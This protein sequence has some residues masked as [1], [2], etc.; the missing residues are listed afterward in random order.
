MLHVDMDA[1]YVSVSLIDRPELR[2]LPV[3]V[4]GGE[5]GVVLSAS[6]EARAYGVSSA[7]PMSRARRLCPQATIVPPD[8]TAYSEASAGVM[9]IFRSVTP[10]VEP[11]SL[12][13]AFLD[14]S[15]A[16]RRLGPADHIAELI[17]A[18]VTDE[19]GIT[20]SV[21][22]AGTKFVAKLASTSCKPDGLLV[23]RDSDVVTFLHPLP[24]RALWGVGEKTGEILDRLGLRTVGDLAHTPAGTLRRALGHATGSHL[25]A[26]SWGRDERVVVPYEPDRSTGA[27]ET[28]ARDVDDP[29]VVHRE[30]LRLSERT[31]ARMRAA[32]HVGRTVTV[33]VRFA[34]FTTITR[35]RTLPEHTDTGREIYTTARELFDGLGLQRA[36]LRLVGVRV[37]ALGPSGRPRQM[38]L[39]E[40]PAGWREADRAVDRA[41]SRFGD[42]T[43]RPG[44]LLRGGGERSPPA[45]SEP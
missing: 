38:L 27:E 16:V 30:L 31:A 26:L 28:F 33:K 14:V 22:V 12:D 36:R 40:R 1:F 15:G 23:V 6:Y 29:A 44:T 9:E 19:Q 8:F 45:R 4:G 10:L 43:V 35:S 32:G 25:A 39:G 42:G 20:C 11:L 13:E 41:A 34:D 3:V 24:V 7:M 21:G 18:R 5:R 37:E 17:R 2:G